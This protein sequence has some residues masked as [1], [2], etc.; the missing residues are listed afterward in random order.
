MF[1]DPTVDT[2]HLPDGDPLLFALLLSLSKGDT[3]TIKRSD[4]GSLLF[5]CDMLTNCELETILNSMH[6]PSDSLTTQNAVDRL[7]LKVRRGLACEPEVSFVAAH[8]HEIENLGSLSPDEMDMVLGHRHLRIDSE[9]SL[10]RLISSS[11]LS[12][13]RHIECEYLSLPGLE[14][15]I[16]LV[17]VDQID[18]DIWASVCRRL[19]RAPRTAPISTRFSMPVFEYDVSGEFD[20]ILSY[21]TR[22][23]FGN[24]HTSG[25]VGITA[26]S[27]KWNSVEQVADHGW[28]SYWVSNN[29]ANQWIRFDF[30][31]SGVALSGYTLKSGTGSQHLVKWV[32]EGSNNGESWT[33]IDHQETQDLNGEN[34]IKR[35]KCQSAQFFRFIQ[36]RQTGLNSKGTHAMALCNIE[37]FGKLQTK[38]ITGHRRGT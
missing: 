26:S 30:R 4:I 22:T 3:I 2:Y 13:L 10:L 17:S 33:K 6:N 18:A 29:T 14:R 23:G 1:T 37:F 21:L 38:Q 7:A 9:D 27:T 5:L 19:R 11:D 16:T 20:G 31:G 24:V 34:V 25:V 32:V 36:V 35:F 8:F 12:L 28:G 15:F